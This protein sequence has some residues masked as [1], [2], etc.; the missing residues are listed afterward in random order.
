M[1]SHPGWLLLILGLVIAAIGSAWI[2][3]PTIPWLGRLPGDIV[4][5]RGNTRVSFPITTC[6]LTSIVLRGLLWLIRRFFH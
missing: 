2:F 5:Q 6:I 4:I 3:A 1:T